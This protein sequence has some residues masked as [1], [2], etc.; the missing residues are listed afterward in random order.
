MEQHAIR[1][2]GSRRIWPS[3][4][5]HC[6]RARDQPTNA[7]ALSDTG[8]FLIVRRSIDMDIF[9]LS[10]KDRL[11]RLF[12]RASRAWWLPP[13]PKQSYDIYF[14][15]AES[16]QTFGFSLFQGNLIRSFGI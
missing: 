1:C 4:Q 8:V 5:S 6:A 11:T 2:G 3:C 14:V 9:Q 16:E 13:P 15:R 7:N 12:Q 10:P